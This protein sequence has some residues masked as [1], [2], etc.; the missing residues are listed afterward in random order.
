M[1]DLNSTFQITKLNFYHITSLML[2][3]NQFYKDE[4]NL[5]NIK[6]Y[7]DILKSIDSS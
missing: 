6:M 2:Y 3:I 7:D 4:L 1:R 5:I